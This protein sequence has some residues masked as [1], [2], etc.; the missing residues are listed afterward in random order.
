M[1]SISVPES[2]AEMRAACEKRDQAFGV[3]VGY[4]GFQS[5]MNVVE[6]GVEPL[7]SAE[8]DTPAILE[9]WL[10]RDLAGSEYLGHGHG[11]WPVAPASIVTASG[12]TGP[13]AHRVTAR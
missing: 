3:C 7:A 1:R 10:E 4:P 12:P 9:E 8:V 13:R 5:W 6:G 2:M 11:W